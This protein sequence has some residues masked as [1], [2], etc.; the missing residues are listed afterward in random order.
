MLLSLFA[1]MRAELKLAENLAAAMV[2]TKASSSPA[3]AKIAVAKSSSTGTEAGN[4]L[5]LPG[6]LSRSNT[7]KDMADAA[8]TPLGI[9]AN[10]TLPAG[11]VYP[12]A[13]EVRDVVK[14]LWSMKDKLPPLNIANGW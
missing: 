14:R 3:D 6:K 11:E 9:A 8:H 12:P 4:T 1:V 2:D 7:R 10:S 13:N 5:K